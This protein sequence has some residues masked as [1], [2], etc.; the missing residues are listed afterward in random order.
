MTAYRSPIP[1]LKSTRTFYDRDGVRVTRDW[2]VVG[3]QHYEVASLRD[4]VRTRGRK[5]AGFTVSMIIAGTDAVLMLPVLAIVG[6]AGLLW[7]EV[8]AAVLV[9]AL[10][11]VICL[12]R[13]P[14]R[15]QLWARYRGSE[16]SLYS[17]RDARE[18][19]HVSRAVQRAIELVPR[20]TL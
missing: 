6:G 9:P 20:G 13:W 2:F 10:I 8:A 15:Q 7:L 11:A 16:V 17:T 19:G 18:F 4:V 14:P 1:T 3:D 12:H 5:H